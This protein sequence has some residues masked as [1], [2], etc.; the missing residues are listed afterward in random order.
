MDAAGQQMN[1]PVKYSPFS[2]LKD[3]FGHNRRQVDP[4]RRCPVVV[5]YRFFQGIFFFIFHYTFIL[6]IFLSGIF[7][8]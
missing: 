4:Q 6:I 3:S 8:L 1:L 7:W 2:F 5:F